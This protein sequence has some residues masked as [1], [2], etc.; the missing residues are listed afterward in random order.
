M[1]EQLLVNHVH[2]STTHVFGRALN[3]VRT[4]HFVIDGT[5]EPK[6]EITPVEAFLAAV[7]ACGVHLIERFAREAGTDLQKVEC[8]IEGT[9]LADDPTRFQG[10]KLH[11]RLSGPSQ[12]Q[13]EELVERF[14]GR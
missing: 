7:S 4:H 8:D 11:F 6:E 12:Q 3:S 5:T 14:K 1:S 9:R 13:A 10:V 2:S